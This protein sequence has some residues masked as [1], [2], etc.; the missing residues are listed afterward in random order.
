VLKSI[1]MLLRQ[2][3]TRGTD[4]VAR[5]GGEEF[6]AVLPNTSADSAIR[7]AEEIVQALQRASIPH[8]YPSVVCCELFTKD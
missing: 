8:E 2:C 4:L 5:Y 3:V 1:G 7:I 6:C